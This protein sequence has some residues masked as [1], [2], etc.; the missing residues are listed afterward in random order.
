MAIIPP[1][2]GSFF[3]KVGGGAKIAGG[4]AGGVVGAGAV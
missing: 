1:K 3:G 4:V 2:L